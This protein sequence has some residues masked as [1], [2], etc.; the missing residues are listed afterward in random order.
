MQKMV[1]LGILSVHKLMVKPK[2]II[3][4]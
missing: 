4:M 2:E 1:P 3:Y